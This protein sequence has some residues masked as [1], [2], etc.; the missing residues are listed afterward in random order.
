MAGFNLE[1]EIDFVPDTYRQR[2]YLALQMPQLVRMWLIVKAG[3]VLGYGV[4]SFTFSFEF[5]GLL[6]TLD[7][8]YVLQEYRGK[9][10]GVEVLELL[11]QQAKLLG[12]QVLNGDISDHKPW[13]G[14]FYQRAGFIPHPYRPYYR[15]L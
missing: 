3:T 6:A 10:I 11:A 1:E 13:L 8:I 7:E 9:G 14:A 5:G 12:A 15:Q 2:I 4:L